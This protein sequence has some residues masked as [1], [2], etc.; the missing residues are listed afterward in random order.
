MHGCDCVLS[1]IHILFGGLY[2]FLSKA[3]VRLRCVRGMVALRRCELRLCGMS[4]GMDTV[5]RHISKFCIH[6]LFV[7]GRR[8]KNPDPM[9]GRFM[10]L[11]G[12]S[13]RDATN[14]H[15]YSLLPRAPMQCSSSNNVQC[16]P[17]AHVSNVSLRANMRSNYHPSHRTCHLSEHRQ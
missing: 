3:T 8:C 1:Y 16:S 2:A 9:H 13:N 10:C 17:G 7:L 5:A 4:L 14:L 11:I 12:A 6:F 15:S